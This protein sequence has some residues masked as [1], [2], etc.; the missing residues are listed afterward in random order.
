M[1]QPSEVLLPFN[2]SFLSSAE[3]WKKIKN[4]KSIIS[5]RIREKGKEEKEEKQRRRSKE[6]GSDV[7]PIST[8]TSIFKSNSN[9]KPMSRLHK[10][11]VSMNTNPQ[12]PA[13]P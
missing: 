8:S 13:L 1:T 9:A 2:A 12:P 11:R 3:A 5:Y 4:V 6:E 10:I 7:N